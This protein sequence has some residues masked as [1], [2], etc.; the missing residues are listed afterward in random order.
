MNNIKIS[1]MADYIDLNVLKDMTGNDE[2]FI[3]E[4]IQT[5]LDSAPADFENLKKQYNEGDIESLGKTAHKM[6]GA[7][8]SMGIIGHELLFT[9][10]QIG[11]G[12]HPE[13]DLDK[14]YDEFTDLFPKIINELKNDL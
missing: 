13:S 6:K 4:M 1:T 10:E 12:N 5:Y 11:K 3:K 14:S 7:T 9:I 2:E 8:R